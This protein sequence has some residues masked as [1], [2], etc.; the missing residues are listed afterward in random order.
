ML[1]EFKENFCI[2]LAEL[3]E[4]VASNMRQGNSNI[5]YEEMDAITDMIN[6]STIKPKVVDRIGVTSIL[7]CTDAEFYRLKDAGLIKEYDDPN[8]VGNNYLV[9]D[10]E[11]L[12]LS[13]KVIERK[14][15]YK[16]RRNRL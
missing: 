15:D 7:N 12:R 1:S 9:S 16:Y 2:S 10:I 3:L 8:L 13:G 14:R 11:E 5:T 6:R 4:K